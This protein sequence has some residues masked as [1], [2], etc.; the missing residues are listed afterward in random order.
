MSLRVHSLLEETDG[1]TD[2][3]KTC[4]KW[5]LLQNRVVRGVKE[6]YKAAAPGQGGRGF[7][8]LGVVPTWA[9]KSS[10]EVNVMHSDGGLWDMWEGAS[11]RPLDS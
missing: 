6:V 3:G 2:K 10:R 9:E 11:S 5:S 8:S 7:L 4:I 1:D